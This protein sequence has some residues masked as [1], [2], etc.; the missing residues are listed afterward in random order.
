[1]SEIPPGEHVLQL[2]LPSDNPRMPASETEVRLEFDRDAV[3]LRN[4]V[5]FK[6]LSSDYNVPVPAETI[7][8]VWR[9]TH[10]WCVHAAVALRKNS[11]GEL[12]AIPL[13]P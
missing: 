6:I 8:C 13:G 10:R 11:R 2:Q 12:V 1:M 3:L 7:K 9:S 4:A 5:T